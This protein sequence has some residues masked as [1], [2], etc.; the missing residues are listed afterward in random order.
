[1][2]TPQPKQD[3][4]QDYLPHLTLFKQLPTEVIFICL[5]WKPMQAQ[6]PTLLFSEET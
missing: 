3:L 1:M 4:Q 2:N 6:L 5:F